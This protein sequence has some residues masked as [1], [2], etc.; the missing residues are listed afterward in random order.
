[1][2]KDDDEVRKP[3]VERLHVFFFLTVRGDVRTDGR[4]RLIF[5]AC[6]SCGFVCVTAQ[7]WKRSWTTRV[8]GF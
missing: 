8:L 7:S 6:V 1:M 3:P 2:D 4:K 5:E